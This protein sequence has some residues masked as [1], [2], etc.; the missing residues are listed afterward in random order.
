ML[1]QKVNQNLLFDSNF[2][3]SNGKFYL[4]AQY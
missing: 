1:L 2:I 3:L 4:K